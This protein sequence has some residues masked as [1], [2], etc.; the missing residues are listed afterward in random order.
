M[1]RLANANRAFRAENGVPART[2]GRTPQSPS[3]IW[4][5]AETAVGGCSTA[6]TTLKS[7][8]GS[9]RYLGCRHSVQRQSW[10]LPP[11]LRAALRR[12][13]D[14]AAAVREASISAPPD[15]GASPTRQFPAILVPWHLCMIRLTSADQQSG[16]RIP[17]THGSAEN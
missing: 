4:Q 10:R 12:C 16:M 11:R 3:E 9:T 15:R 17:L 14:G 8:T 1:R 7:K 5:A 2:G 13:L 6:S